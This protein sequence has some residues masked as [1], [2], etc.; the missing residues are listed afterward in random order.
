[1]LSLE[2]EESVCDTVFARVLKHGGSPQSLERAA[3]VQFAGLK[4][5]ALAS[6]QS[7]LIYT[8]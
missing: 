4:C 3:T 6:L 7:S 5:C 8:N 2:I 1:M